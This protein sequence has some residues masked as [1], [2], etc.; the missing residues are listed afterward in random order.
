MAENHSV[1]ARLQTSVAKELAA[2]LAGLALVA[3]ILAH[4]AGNFY[5]FF[6]PEAFNGYAEKLKSLGPLLWLAR[7]GLIIM[8]AT[9]LAL[10]VWIRY[11][12]LRAAGWSRYAV[13]TTSG[14][15]TI[16]KRTM[17]YSGILMVCFLALHLKDF[18]LASKEG[19]G[20]DVIFFGVEMGLFG[21]VWNAFANPLHAAIYILAV[22]A[23]GLHFSNALS[24]VW[25]TT[26][27]LS[28]KATRAANRAALALGMAIALAFSSI[29]VY[30]LVRTYLL[31]G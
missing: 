2:A 8:F 18:T 15:T 24:S 29:P 7:A 23:V 5:L 28:E 13:Q 16:A 27:L 1:A 4:L 22:F 10:S 25:V 17:L 3:F 30:V 26:G 14:G 9:H 12:G 31:K 6:G 21:L 19:V 11:T 20:T